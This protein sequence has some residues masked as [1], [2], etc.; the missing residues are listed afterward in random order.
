M[1]FLVENIKVSHCLI[2]FLVEMRRLPN[3]KNLAEIRPQKPNHPPDRRFFMVQFFTVC[4]Q[5]IP[6]N[7]VQSAVQ[8]NRIL[9]S[10]PPQQ[11]CFALQ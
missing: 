2:I 6:D 10:P 9:P 11:F 7:L 5:E 1:A 4:F 8:F 3:I